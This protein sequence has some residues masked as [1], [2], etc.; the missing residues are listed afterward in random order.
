MASLKVRTVF[1]YEAAVLGLSF[2][3]F[4][5]SFAQSVM[6]EN[7]TADAMRHLAWSRRMNRFLASRTH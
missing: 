2:R 4:A 5:R 7:N 6:M 1:G 3:D